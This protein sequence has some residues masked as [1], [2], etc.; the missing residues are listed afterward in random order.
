[1]PELRRRQLLAGAAA[2]AGFATVGLS[3]GAAAAATRQRPGA[4]R[5]PSLTVGDRAVVGRVDARRALQHLKVLSDE[6]GWRIA[7]TSS[8]HRAA[9]YIAKV[10]R[11]LG[12]KVT[13]QPFPVAD[14]YLAEMKAPQVHWQCSAAPRGA[15]ASAS[16][17][18]VDLGTATDVTEDVTGRLVLFTR[19]AG[20][21]TAQAKA[22]AAKGAAAVLIANVPSATFPER[23]AAAFT[24]SLTEDVA[25][26]V[27]GVAQYHGEQIRGGVS[28]LDLTVTHHSGLTSYNVLAERRAT[29]PN[30]ERKTV[31]VSA[32][33]DSVPGSPG[34]N[35]DGSGTV[36]CLELARVLRRLPTQQ[37]I[38]IA[39]WGSE[40]YGLIGARHYVGQLT[41][42]QVAQIS[43]CFQNDM[44]ATSH[45]P[46]GTYWLL[47]VDGA[48]N[49]TTAAVAAAA[50]RLGYSGQVKGPTA[51]GS[52]DHE[53]FFERGIDAGNFSW[54]GGEAPS[55]LEPIYHTPEDTIAKNISLQRLQV[56]LEL[57]GCAVYDVARR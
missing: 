20:S 32:H 16:G 42:E 38:R 50:E 25:I 33:Y 52:S 9:R 56:S 26:P 28:R 10:L 46:A 12:Y 51:R 23:K 47:S 11:D 55:Q 6:I 40:E 8:E 24:P 7:G 35:D 29:L 54:R 1:M 44:V 13:L 49:T 15:V 34:A 57:I 5:L 14:K 17:P 53:A 30:P 41:D 3:P 4:S 18:V 43:G 21:E 31:I 27:L 45:P 36:L 39:L 37:D 22:A 19:V 2:L 48:D